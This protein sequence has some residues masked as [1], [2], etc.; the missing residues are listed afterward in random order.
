MI[1]AT[2]LFI[3]STGVFLLVTHAIYKALLF[4]AAG[5]VIH[6]IQ[7]KQDIRFMSGLAPF[8]VLLNCSFIVASFALCAAPYTSGDFSKDAIIEGIR[9]IEVS[10]RNSL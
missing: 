3:P 5:G 10:F 4:L 1:A 6:A 7:G 9:M 2:G 8:G